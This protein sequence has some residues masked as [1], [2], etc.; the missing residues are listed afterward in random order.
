MLGVALLYV[1][2]VLFVNAMWLL[3]KTDAKGAGVLNACVG[4]LIFLLAINNEFHAKDMASSFVTAQ[5]LLFAFTYLWLAISCF[6]SLDN[7][8]LGYYCLVVALVAVPT[9][10]HT[11]AAGDWRFGLI[12]LM[13][14]A[15]WF[16]FFLFMGLGRQILKFTAFATMGVAAVTGAVGYAI[17]IERW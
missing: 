14:A 1:G 17:L 8:A 11:F 4:G 16:T 10:I 5:F 9:S 15:L 7:R 3:N 12:W 2:A 6:L 13:W